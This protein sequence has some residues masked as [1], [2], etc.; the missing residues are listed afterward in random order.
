MNEIFDSLTRDTDPY[1]SCD[2]CFARIDEYAER[3]SA[4]PGHRDVAM[5]THLAGCPACA[6]EAEALLELLDAER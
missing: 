1:L 3:L 2:D 6:E 4:D 5:Q